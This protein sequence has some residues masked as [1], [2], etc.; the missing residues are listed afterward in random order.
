MRPPKDFMRPHEDFMRPH[1][2]FMRP[3][4]D[5]MRLYEV[6]QRLYE[7]F[8]QALEAS[9]CRHIAILQGLLRAC[10]GTEVPGY[11]YEGRLRG[12]NKPAKAG[13]ANQE[14]G[15]SAPRIQ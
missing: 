6:F 3:H 7:V 11:G 5:F 10:R 15:A 14:P 4:E 9:L 2:D 12:L 13:F 1:E 8:I